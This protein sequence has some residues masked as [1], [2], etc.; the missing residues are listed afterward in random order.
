MS[1][2]SAPADPSAPAEPPSL[3]ADEGT[4]T[5]PAWL[6]EAVQR[7]RATPVPPDTLPAMDF[8]P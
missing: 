6:R 5:M 8:R 7:V 3:P 4:A 1:Q 2:Q